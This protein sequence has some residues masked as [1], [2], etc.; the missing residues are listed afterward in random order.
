MKQMVYLLLSRQAVNFACSETAWG[1]GGGG[2]RGGGEEV[3]P[4][5]AL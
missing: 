5:D 1:G 3:S 2:N 4:D